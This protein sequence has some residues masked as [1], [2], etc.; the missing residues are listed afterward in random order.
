MRHPFEKWIQ[1]QMILLLF[2]VFLGILTIWTSVLFFSFMTCISIIA[3]ICIDGYI[4]LLK[5]HSTQAGHQIIR[6]VILTIFISYLYLT[7]L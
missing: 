3:S 2:A 6:A 1:L 4:E 7:L 5:G